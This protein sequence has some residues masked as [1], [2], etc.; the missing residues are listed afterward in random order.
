M[1]RV[2]FHRQRGARRLRKPVI[3]I[4][5]SGR[6]LIVPWLI[7]RADPCGELA[8]LRR[9]NE[10]DKDPALAALIQRMELQHERA[11]FGLLHR[12][13]A[14]R[15]VIQLVY[16][17]GWSDAKRLRSMFVRSIQIHRANSRNAH[18]DRAR[19]L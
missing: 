6:P 2:T 18:H 3:V 9:R 15:G 13:R 11:L 1:R 8:S 17:N 12:V 7:E 16:R 10:A 5:F 19:D 14:P 4:L